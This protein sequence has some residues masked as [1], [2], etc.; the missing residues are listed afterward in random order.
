MLSS[1]WRL[2]TTSTMP[3][4]LH[5]PS[6]ALLLQSALL[7]MLS[8]CFCCCAMI[9]NWGQGSFYGPPYALL[10]GSLADMAQQPPFEGSPAVQKGE[11]Q[12]I[13]VMTLPS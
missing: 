11:E 5:A 2:Q 8:C 10:Q 12:D 9:Q 1:F 13:R 7:H 4:C 3:D 6:A